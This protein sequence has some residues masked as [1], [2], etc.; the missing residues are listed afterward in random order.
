MHHCHS[1]TIECSPSIPGNTLGKN[2]LSL[3]VHVYVH[4]SKHHTKKKKNFD[5]LFN[6]ALLK[7]LSIPIVTEKLP[8]NKHVVLY[9]IPFLYDVCIHFCFLA[10]LCHC[11]LLIICILGSINCIYSAHKCKL[12]YFYAQKSG[13]LVDGGSYGG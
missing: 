2:K 11:N 5:M 9:Y 1:A 4:I 12:F 6:L 8:N 7:V 13:T 10:L 3:Y